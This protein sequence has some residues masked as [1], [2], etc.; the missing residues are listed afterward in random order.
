MSEQVPVCVLAGGGGYLGRLLS[1]F[2]TG[3]GFSVA[4]LTRRPRQD[5][6]M[7]WY[8]G[9]DGETV[10]TWVK[11][12]DGAA[13]V[14][15]LAGRTVNCRYNEA[16]KQ[17]IYDSR[18]K[19]TWAIGEA[20]SRCSSPPPIWINSSSATIYRHA[21]DRAMDE[22]T[23]QLGSGFSVD[24][25]QK[26]EKTLTDATTPK[27]RKVALRT[28]MVFGAGQGGV[29]EAFLRIVRLGL[30]GPMGN[31][32]QYVSWIHERDFCR[33]VHWILNH[34]ELS[35]PVNV[36]SPNPLP[37]REFMQIFRQVCEQK[38][39]LPAAAWMLEIGA[40]VLQT[41]TELLL[42][43]R[44]VVPGKLLSTGFTFDFP[45]WET[46]LKDIVRRHQQLKDN[47]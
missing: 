30:G 44:R 17:E 7:V 4:I 25:C 5:D 28:A 26:W 46:A 3:Q 8:V 42:K 15:N 35:G 13:A 10:G 20:I 1:K 18:L 9:W 23:G 29:F 14:I 43:S 21:E 39:G 37:N 27:T 31:G 12:L 34:K 41:E 33:A 24:V 32:Q 40:A 2:L 11:D 45:Q 16:N 6:G 36:A 47:F 19:S 38:V 22:A